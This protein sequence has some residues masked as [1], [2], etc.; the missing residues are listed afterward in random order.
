MGKF[1]D[2]NNANNESKTFGI[3]QNAKTKY[4]LYIY[5]FRQISLCFLIFRFI[6]FRKKSRKFA[7]YKRI[8]SPETLVGIG[9]TIVKI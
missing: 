1:L 2:K 3:Y 7:K 4:S 5:G 6:H 8:F 9:L